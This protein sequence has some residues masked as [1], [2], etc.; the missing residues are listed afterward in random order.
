M[1]DF[2][3][4]EN[5]VGINFATT[6]YGAIT[7]SGANPSALLSGI[8]T[9]FDG[10]SGMTFIN[11]IF[12]HF[13]IFNQLTNLMIVSGST[14]TSMH[15]ESL[16]TGSII[17]DLGN[18]RSINLIKI[19]LLDTDSRQYSYYIDI[20]LDGED[21]IRLID[22]TQ[23]YCRSW[24]YLY[25]QLRPV[26]FI[27]IV[28]TGA[29]N[30]V[31]EFFLRDLFGIV[32]LQALYETTNIPKL[33]DGVIK[34]INN[35]AIEGSALGLKGVD[36]NEMLNKNEDAFSYHEKGSYILLSF[37]QPYHID[38]LRMLLGN[39][40]FPLDKFSFG[41]QT[42]MDLKT[43]KMAVDKRNENLSGWQEFDFELRPAVFIK[44]T[45]TQSDNV[46][47]LHIF[48][49][50]FQPDEKLV[51]VNCTRGCHSQYHMAGAQS[52]YTLR[53]HSFCRQIDNFFT[54]FFGI[55]FFSF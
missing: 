5:D 6:K 36:A 21:Y 52:T 23:H 17:V 54:T 41:I 22:H 12:K 39:N 18:I 50:K 27:K 8:F 4:S 38:S 26:K 29:I 55:F 3:D 46:S 10:L 32:G 43:W 44:I 51:N 16:D 9:G 19:L 14:Y 37:N 31:G 47:T 40:S 49:L 1:F 35:V 45:G 30:V 11:F 15:P 33:V 2:T 53:I 7:I 42:S 25:F 20:S 13:T 48:M 28:G 24:Q 34:P